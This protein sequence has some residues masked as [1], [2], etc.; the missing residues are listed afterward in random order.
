MTEY[1]GVPDEGNRMPHLTR[2]LYFDV[3]S[4]TIW[5]DVYRLTDAIHA[6][7]VR[8]RTRETVGRD[9]VFSFPCFDVVPFIIRHEHYY[10][11]EPFETTG[12]Y[13]LRGRCGAR[14]ENLDVRT[15]V[16][17]D[18]VDEVD[19]SGLDALDRPGLAGRVE[20][21]WAER[22]RHPKGLGMLSGPT[23]TPP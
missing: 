20:E 17:L 8:S 4:D 15:L 18:D 10:N 2:S 5:I 1:T 21:M 12:A 22:M 3:Q 6:F 14:A 9:T 19:E 7:S 16:S 13:E 23:E 11:N